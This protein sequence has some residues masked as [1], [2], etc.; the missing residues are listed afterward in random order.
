MRHGNAGDRDQVATLSIQVSEIAGDQAEEQ[1]SVNP[2]IAADRQGDVLPTRARLR[3]DRT[4]SRSNAEI[5]IDRL[6]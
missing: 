2:I 6:P 4:R 5:A 1:S 3:Q